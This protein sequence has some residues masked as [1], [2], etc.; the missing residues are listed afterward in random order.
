MNRFL[1]LLRTMRAWV[2]GSIALAAI[3][4]NGIVG[5]AAEKPVATLKGHTAGISS[6]A[7][8]PDGKTLASGSADKTIKLWDVSGSEVKGRGILSGHTDE[9]R[10]I[11]FSP[12]GNMLASASADKTIRLWDPAADK[13]L[14]ALRGHEIGVTT[15]AFSPNGKLLASA[16][17]NLRES[18]RSEIRLW[19]C[20]GATVKERA[21]LPDGHK[22]QSLAFSPDS[23]A[24]AY[25]SFG[26]KLWDVASG[27]EVPGPKIALFGDVCSV[28]YSP[29]GKTLAYAM[30]Y[31][32]RPASIV[33]LDLKTKKAQPEIAESIWGL[34][35]V[36]YSPDGKLVAAWGQDYNPTTK[37]RLWDFVANRERMSITTSGLAGVAFSPDSRWIATAEGDLAIKIWKL[38]E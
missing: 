12:S 25:G 28:A 37:L 10:C 18:Y 22:V 3:A 11:A 14:A 19:D 29:D 38:E 30:G 16:A 27:K 34:G 7:F 4:F 1:R 17:L 24:L 32:N 26:L 31:V 23:A 13:E 33:L 21:V 15:L 35:R 5:S 6:I 9:I 36:L 2:S 8:S 20:D